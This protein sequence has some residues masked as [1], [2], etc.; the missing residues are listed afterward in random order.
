MAGHILER[1][2]SL[3]LRVYI[4]RDPLNPKR[5][6]WRSKTIPKMG[7]RAAGKELAAFVTEV[8]S[9]RPTSPDTFG[10]LLERWYE[11]RSG[12]WSPGTATATRQLIDSRLK[13]L[14]HVKLRDLSVE[15]LDTFYA[16][17]RRRGGRKG[18]PLKA[19]TVVRVHSL[20]RLA[21]EQAL[22]WGHLTTN[23][24]AHA[25]PGRLEP[26][27]IKPPT[28]DQVIELLDA[29][30]EHSPELFL[31]L[32]LD[33]DTGARRGELAALRF[34]DLDGRL[35][36][37]KRA[38]VT[39]P[40]TEENAQRYAG[41]YWPASWARGGRPSAL[42]EKPRPKTRGSRR[43]VTLAPATVELLEA[44]R[45]RLNEAYLA[46]GARYPDDG[47]VFPSSRLEAGRP[48]RPESWTRRFGKLRAELGLDHVRLHDIRHFVATSLLTSGV[49]LATVA[50]RLGHGGG[51]KTTLAIYGH[52]LQAPDEVASDVMAK[53]LER[54]PAPPTEGA[55]VPMRAASGGAAR[56]G[57]A[58]RGARARSE[59]RARRPGKG[60]SPA[61]SRG[62]GD[63]DRT[64]DLNLGKVAL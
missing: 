20:V 64:G 60:A 3:V 55:V 18:G 58:R 62:A 13:P 17:L 15:T 5:R 32:A 59:T 33:A 50:G 7:E 42:I 4:G 6:I 31:F 52:F 38:L 46:G 36:S 8:Q 51:G 43:T 14:H 9:Q 56:H 47:F 11:A 19:S 35:L 37:I 57:G 40:A 34:S 49:D 24:A 30:A 61:V 28:P 16:E 10:E 39:G 29:A 12:D 27:D 21:L 2:D 54:S 25:S 22:K 41:H 45:L 23:P 1:G 44:Q 53:L 48:T 26:T 63:R